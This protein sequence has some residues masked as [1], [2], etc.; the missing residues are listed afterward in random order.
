MEMVF[1]DNYGV[2]RRD[3]QKGEWGDRIDGWRLLNG[4]NRQK[5]NKERNTR[6]AP[7]FT[8]YMGVFQNLLVPTLKRKCISVPSTFHANNSVV[9]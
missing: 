4:E 8:Y 5:T 6:Q 2:K 3:C 7:V 9:T 1:A